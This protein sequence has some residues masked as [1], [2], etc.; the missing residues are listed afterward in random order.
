MGVE[1]GF[2][3]AEAAVEFLVG[4]LEGLFGVDVELA[5]EVDDGE[6]EVA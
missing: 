1:R 6:Q 4:G 5:G 3:V 2:D